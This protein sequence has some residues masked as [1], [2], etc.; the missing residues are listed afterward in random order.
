MPP[1]SRGSAASAV[2]PYSIREYFAGKNLL[3]TGSTGFLA[4]A[5]VEKILRD[6]PE[7]GR[8]YL[9]IRPRARA[10]G[11]LVEPKERLR[12][13]LLRNSVFS[14]LR[15]T[16]GARFEPLCE[17]KITCVP[18]DL[19]R[20]RLGLEPGLYE[21]L[22]QNVQL[23]I[24]SAATVVFDERLDL[25]LDLNTLASSRLLEICHAAGKV[26]A[27]PATYCHISTAYVS[28]KRRGLAPE[29]LLEPLEAI[30]AQLPPGEKRPESFDVPNEVARLQELCTKVK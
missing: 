3:I 1:S 28:G 15:S 8:I 7:A 6:L 2:T 18:G 27:H 24:H 4:K 29:R 5:I 25:A 14:R 21:E 13:D 9:L 30:D 17:S 16:H 22:T 11:S 10:D 12:E 19:T 20:E 26:Q 23:V